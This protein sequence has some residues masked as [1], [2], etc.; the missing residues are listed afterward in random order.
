MSCD[1]C[2]ELRSIDKSKIGDFLVKDAVGETSHKINFVLLCHFKPLEIQRLR[3]VTL[4]ELF[5]DDNGDE[6]LICD[7]ND[8]LTDDG[9]DGFDF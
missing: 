3:T 5:V 1:G 7:L 4:A 9:D 8:I 2:A 6:E